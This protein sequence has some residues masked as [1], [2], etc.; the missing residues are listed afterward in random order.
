M[1]RKNL[2]AHADP[3]TVVLRSASKMYDLSGKQRVLKPKRATISSAWKDVGICIN[4][5]LVSCN[6][7]RTRISK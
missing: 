3:I 1:K 7:R 4:Q 2:T 5:A 6:D